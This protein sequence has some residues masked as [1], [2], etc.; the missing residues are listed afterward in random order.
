MIQR[1]LRIGVMGPGSCDSDLAAKA[2]EVGR[3]IARAGAVLISGGRTGVMQEASK[4]AAEAGGWVIGILPSDSDREANRWVTIPIPTGMGNA[5]N[6][7][8]V[9][10]SQSLIAIAGGP[11]TL[12]EIALAVK[13]GTPVVGLNTWTARNASGDPLPIHVAEDPEHAVTMALE[14]ALERAL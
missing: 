3:R 2:A 9:L 8:N 5:R 11:G 13:A 12:S 4:G 6:A 1:P 10:S 14:L 7:V